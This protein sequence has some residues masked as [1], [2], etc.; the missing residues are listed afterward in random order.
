MYPYCNMTGTNTT[1]YVLLAIVILG[2]VISFYMVDLDIK[3]KIKKNEA[4]EKKIN[5]RQASPTPVITTKDIELVE[6]D[7]ELEEE[8]IHYVGEKSLN[9]SDNIER[10][11]IEMAIEAGISNISDQRVIIDIDNP[12]IGIPISGG[13]KNIVRLAES[14][15][16]TEVSGINTNKNKCIHG[17]DKNM[18]VKC[19]K[20][21]KRCTKELRLALS[22]DKIESARN[23]EI[24]T[25]LNK[26]HTRKL[27]CKEF[28]I[29]KSERTLNLMNPI[30]GSV[31]KDQI[32]HIIRVGKTEEELRKQD[33]IS[34]M[35]I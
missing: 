19:D 30:G 31:N 8:P 12:S 24:R 21:I 16:M 25:E 4:M 13:P 27:D 10:D 1:V 23:T 14:I 20:T 28:E 18:C 2:L 6:P 34:R 33:N 26:E 15:T 9:I 7:N 3:A 35:I 5:I 17:L 11:A 32:N 22:R 29:S